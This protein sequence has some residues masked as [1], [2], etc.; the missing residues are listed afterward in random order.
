MGADQPISLLSLQ[1]G[2][3]LGAKG[4]GGG[5]VRVLIGVQVYGGNNLRSLAA[6]QRSR[7]E[8]Q[9]KKKGEFGCRGDGEE[10]R[11]QRDG[12]T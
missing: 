3:R 8:M 12:E 5:G 9:I 1:G 10:Q 2:F 4:G 11:A 7:R 6:D